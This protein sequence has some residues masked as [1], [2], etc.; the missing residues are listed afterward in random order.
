MPRANVLE[1]NETNIL[2]PVPNFRKLNTFLGTE[3]KLIEGAGF[4]LKYMCFVA[5]LLPLER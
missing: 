3:T 4:V 1:K 2:C 5:L